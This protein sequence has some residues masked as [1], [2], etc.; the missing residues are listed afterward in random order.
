MQFRHE[1]KYPLNYADYLTVRQRLRAVLHK[2]PNADKNGEYKIRSL[3]FDTPEDKALLDKLNGTAIREKFRI[4]LY[5][6]DSSHIKLEKKTKVNGLGNKQSAKLTA[7]Q[8]LAV[9]AG[10][11]DWMINHENELV[12]EFYV[13]LKCQRLEPKVLVDYIREPFVFDAGNVRVTLDRE[14]RTGNAR[15][16]WL[17]DEGITLPTSEN[18]YLME[19]KYDNFLPALIKDIIQLDSRRAAAFSKYAICRKYG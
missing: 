4:R 12:R 6:N 16:N 10:E 7:E 15:G 19:V 5:N 8:A 2:D 11:W 13:K 17:T 9:T 3:Y 18:A 1:L 14:I